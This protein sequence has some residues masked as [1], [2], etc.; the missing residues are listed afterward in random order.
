MNKE[1]ILEAVNS[2][3]SA[4][5]AAKKLDIPYTTFIRKAKELGVYVTNQSGKG[6]SKKSG[7][8]FPLEDIFDGKFPDYQSNKLRR[9]LI[10]EGYKEHICERCQLSE[11][12]G[13]QIPLEVNHI[14]GNNK[15]HKLSNLEIICPNCHAQTET[16]R[17]KNIKTNRKLIPL[18]TTDDL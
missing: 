17:G 18:C 8:K 7:K 2:S 12:N 15:N 13:K 3:P 9:R 16:Y 6:I 4:L 11:W 5:S 10:D 14:D 1:E